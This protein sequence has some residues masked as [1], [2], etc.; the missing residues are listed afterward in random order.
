MRGDERHHDARRAE[1]AL[2]AVL[3]VHGLLHRVQLAA[4]DSDRLDRFDR[5]AI[6]LRR[7]REA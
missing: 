6:G 1:T 5:C 2:Q 3:L 7:E 4:G